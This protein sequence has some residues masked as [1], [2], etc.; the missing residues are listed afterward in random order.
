MKY[1]YGD[2]I[3]E[4][5]GDDCVICITT[6][7]F[8]KKTG[9]AVMGK[10]IAKQIKDK[11]SKI[12]I[13]LGNIIRIAGNEVNVIRDYDKT[14]I[15]AFPVK[16]DKIYVDNPDKV[17]FAVNHMRHKF[18]MYDTIPGWACVADIEIIYES[19]KR[20]VQLADKNKWN[21]IYLPKPGCG[22]GEL[23][24]EDVSPIMEELLDDRFY[25]CDFKR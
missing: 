22:A 8:V 2:L 11:I 19:T 25:I 12:D 5:L 6:N 21:E 7:G 16:P 4:K 10:G 13:Q 23:E 1:W 18:K 20:L 14:K 3:E 17:N 9:Q 24:W 15:V